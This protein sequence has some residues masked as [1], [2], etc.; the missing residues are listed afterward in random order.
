MRMTS[1]STIYRGGKDGRNAYQ[2]G[3]GKSSHILHLRTT[4]RNL[5]ITTRNPA[6]GPRDNG[7]GQT[8]YNTSGKVVICAICSNVR[9]Y[10]ANYKENTQ[11]YHADFIYRI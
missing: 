11:N 7:N 3:C 10:C 5:F 4:G 9:P 2:M 8:Y 6:T 1:D